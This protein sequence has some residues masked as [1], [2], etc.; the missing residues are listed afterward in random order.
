MVIVFCSVILLPAGKLST[1]STIFPLVLYQSTVAV[2]FDGA[3]VTA[4]AGVA[5]M[6][7]P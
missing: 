1:V 7:S 6:I 5:L 2:L 3:M 4:S